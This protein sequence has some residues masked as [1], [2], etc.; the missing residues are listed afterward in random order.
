MLSNPYFPGTRLEQVR[1]CAQ[2]ANIYYTVER[3]K[4]AIWPKKGFRAGD[5]IKIGPQTGMVGYPQFSGNGIVLT[6]LFNPDIA[7]GGRVEVTS[8]LTVARGVW[9]VFKVVHALESETPGGQWFTQVSCFR[10][11]D[12]E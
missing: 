1:A 4:L 10:M 6:T 7:L 3:G 9:N 2:S 5:T 12:A 11:D 8:D